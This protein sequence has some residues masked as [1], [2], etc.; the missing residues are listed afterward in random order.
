MRAD[1]ALQAAVLHV[2]VNKAPH[3]ARGQAAA[4]LYLKIPLPAAGPSGGTG[5][6]SILFR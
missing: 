5:A 2:L 1:A 3:A 4:A 6:A